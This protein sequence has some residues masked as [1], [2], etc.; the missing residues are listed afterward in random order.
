MSALGSTTATRSEFSPD[1]THGMIHPRLSPTIVQSNAK[2]LDLEHVPSPSQS[3]LSRASDSSR[4]LISMSEGELSFVNGE[5]SMSSG[6]SCPDI[7]HG[8]DNLI[9]LVAER[10]VKL[11]LSFQPGYRA[12]AHTGSDKTPSTESS[13]P[14]QVQTGTTSA[15]TEPSC[16][17]NQ[18]ASHPLTNEQDDPDDGV[19]KRPPRGK[20]KL[21]DN[22][23]APKLLACPY[24]KFNSSK[25]SRE[26]VTEQ[27]YWNCSTCCLRTISRLKQHLYRTH[28]RPDYYCSSC[29][30]SYPSRVKLD[31]HGRQRPPCDLA[32]PKYTDKMTDD[33]LLAIKR[34]AKGGDEPEIWYG[35]YQTLFPD[36]PKPSSPYTTTTDPALVSHFVNLFRTIGPQALMDV[37]RDRHQHPGPHPALP[38]STQTIADEAFE[39]ALPYYLRQQSSLPLYIN[40]ILEDCD[41][42]VLKMPLISHPLPQGHQADLMS[43]LREGAADLPEV[44]E[45]SLSALD[46]AAQVEQFQ[47]LATFDSYGDT[48]VSGPSDTTFDRDLH[49]VSG[50][51]TFNWFSVNGGMMQTGSAANGPPQDTIVCQLCGVAHEWEC[52]LRY[53]V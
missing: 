39:I 32:E 1:A 17:Q 51:A 45:Q 42:E 34:R 15:T 24:A 10:V 6:A 29:Y 50:P 21:E 23:L 16:V 5:R 36:S 33:Q 14:S 8:K 53:S 7:N 25:Y 2:T 26:N 41:E 35:I 44:T 27:E 18:I 22:S 9:T 3:S 38:A 30:T 11:C 31:E 48:N 19:P 40:P 43:T 52:P 12:A 28:K 47:L 49:S 20:R 46:W 13:S 37:L 4:S